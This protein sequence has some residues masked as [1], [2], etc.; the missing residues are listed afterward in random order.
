L[1]WDEKYSVEFA[2]YLLAMY[3][4]RTVNLY[5]L[6]FMQFRATMPLTNIETVKELFRERKELFKKIW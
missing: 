1:S 2:E 3:L 5:S 4:R 6:A